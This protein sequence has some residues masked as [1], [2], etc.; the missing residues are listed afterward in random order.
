MKDLS[1]S[2]EKETQ[3]LQSKLSTKDDE[4]G[5]LLKEKVQLETEIKQLENLKT[6]IDEVSIELTDC[7]DKNDALRREVADRDEK[8]ESLNSSS[9]DSSDQLERLKIENNKLTAEMTEV[10]E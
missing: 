10:K 7:K 5:G 1:G 6:R 3:E 8:I 9:C 4:C 2:H